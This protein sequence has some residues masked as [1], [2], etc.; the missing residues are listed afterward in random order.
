MLKHSKAIIQQATYISG[1]D[2]FLNEFIHHWFFLHTGMQQPS[3]VISRN[4]KLECLA[5]ELTHECQRLMLSGKHKT[6][7]TDL[8]A[9]FCVSTV[10]SKSYY[11]TSDEVC[12]LVAQLL[13]SDQAHSVYEPCV[14]PSGISF[15]RV[16]QY[17]EANSHLPNPLL[18]LRISIED[19]DQVALK[20]YFI[21]LIHLL[22]YLTATHG[23]GEVRPDYVHIL[24]VDTLTRKKGQLDISLYSPELH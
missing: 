8:I 18:G 16:E 4:P 2:I 11:P 5:I 13:P 20:A 3:E 1:R 19:I 14:G 7:L 6:P 9:E 17:F 21:Q 15:K 10:R 22:Q 23:E 24:Q 12:K